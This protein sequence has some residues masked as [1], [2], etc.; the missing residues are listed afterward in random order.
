M[1]KELPSVCNKCLGKQ[2]FYY[3][4]SKLDNYFVSTN[5]LECVV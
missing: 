3:F 5:G 2:I 1:C 4:I